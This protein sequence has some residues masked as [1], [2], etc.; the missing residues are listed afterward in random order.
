MCAP[1]LKANPNSPRPDFPGLPAFSPSQISAAVSRKPPPPFSTSEISSHKARPM[2]AIAANLEKSCRHS[3]HAQKTSRYTC[4]P[5][6][7]VETPI[8]CAQKVGLAG[9]FSVE[10]SLLSQ[11]G[12]AGFQNGNATVNA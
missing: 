12:L 7:F 5:T 4:P 10:N 2:L 8:R 1:A 9:F 11:S 3:P 6:A